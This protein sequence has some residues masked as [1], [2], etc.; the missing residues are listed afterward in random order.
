MGASRPT[1]TRKASRSTASTTVRAASSGSSTGTAGR[2]A[3]FGNSTPEWT[4]MSVRMAPGST[5]VTRTGVPWSSAQSPSVRS[6]TAALEAP[7]TVWPGTGRKPPM[8]AT[9]TTWASG[10]ASSR[11]RKAR[12]T[13][14]VP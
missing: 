12:V 4:A 9:L 7:Y 3:A 5:R 8:L 1:R 14:R 2:T 13:N 10:R 11:G 6:F